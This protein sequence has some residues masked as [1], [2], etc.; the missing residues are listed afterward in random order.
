MVTSARARTTWANASARACANVSSGS[1]RR[2]RRARVSTA[3]HIGADC[4]TGSSASQWSV[5]IDAGDRRT[6][7]PSR[8]AF[9]CFATSSGCARATMRRTRARNGPVVSSHPPR[10]S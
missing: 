9:A 5:P 8:A 4:S 2:N 1:C 10:A 7:R 6:D 3:C